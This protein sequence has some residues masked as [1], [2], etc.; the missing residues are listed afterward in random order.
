VS[1][2]D[3][4]HEWAAAGPDEVT[5]NPEKYVFNNIF[6][7]LDDRVIFRD[8]LAA[9][10]SHYDGNVFYRHT[11]ADLPLFSD[12]GDGGRYDSLLDFQANSGIDWEIHGL[13]ID[14]GFDLS[15]INDPTF[16]PAVIWQRYRPGNEQIFTSGASYAGLD[17]PETQDVNYR[18]AIPP[19]IDFTMFLPFVK[20]R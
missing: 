12:F 1:R 18:G 6:Y 7:L 20:D 17:W 11:V 16:D 10:G 5:G 13:E 19:F 3:P 9:F 15:A 14:P 8:D 4:G 2:Q